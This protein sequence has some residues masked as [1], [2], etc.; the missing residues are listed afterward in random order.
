[1]LWDDYTPK[2]RRK[3]TNAIVSVGDY[4]ECDIDY[5]VYLEDPRLVEACQAV[6]ANAGR[7]IKKLTEV[8]EV[9]QIWLSTSKLRD[10]THSSCQSV[11]V[12]TIW[13][14]LN[15]EGFSWSYP[16]FKRNLDLLARYGY[17]EDPQ[18]CVNSAQW[19]F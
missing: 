3:L 11:A 9:K 13:G 19:M 10:L 8:W 12:L 2:E 7:E 5:G 4:T 14:S 15:E 6:V 17:I 18:E 16:A 1:M